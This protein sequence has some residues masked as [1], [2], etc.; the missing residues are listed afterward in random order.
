LTLIIDSYSETNYNQQFGLWGLHPSADGKESASGQTFTTPGEPCKIASVKFY[1]RKVGSPTGIAHAVLYAMTGTY[2]TS[3]KP[4]GSALA[5]SDGLDV[6]TLPTDFQLITLTFTGD[7]QYV[8]QPNTHYALS[9]ENPTSGTIDASNYVDVGEDS[10]SPT[11]SGNYF[12]W[13]SS[14]WYPS[15]DWDTIFYVYGNM[16]STAELVKTCLFDNWNDS[17]GIAA[18]DVEWTVNRVDVATWLKTGTKNYLIA[19][20]SP[21][22]T[23]S[24]PISHSWWQITEVVTVDVVVKTSVSSAYEKRTIMQDEI[25]RIIHSNQTSITGVSVAYESREPIQVEAENLLRLTILV[26]CVY[27]HSK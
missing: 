8:M 22:A 1:L 23:S 19:V 21:G 13:F 10:T 12:E 24:K 5:T 17:I 27:F 9:I 4:T 14:N 26:T 11:H 16:V 20:Y 15:A 2:G 3:G 6:S 7:Q 25:R 18:A